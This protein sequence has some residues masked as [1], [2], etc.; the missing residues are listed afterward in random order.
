MKLNNE[1]VYPLYHGRENFKNLWAKQEFN[2]F[3]M[4]IWSIDMLPCIMNERCALPTDMHTF[5]L[6]LKPTIQTY[7]PNIG[8]KII[9]LRPIE[10]GLSQFGSI[11]QPRL[12]LRAIRNPYPQLAIKSKP[13]VVK[14]LLNV[15][16]T[17]RDFAIDS[18]GVFGYWEALLS[19][20]WIMLGEETR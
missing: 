16:V 11:F 3:Q 5:T 13:I 18:G 1:T 15:R 14:S 17:Q 12:V 8:I 20:L 7:K 10:G 6:L 4:F 19:P 2:I 9:W